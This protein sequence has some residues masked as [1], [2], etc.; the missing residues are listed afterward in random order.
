MIMLA[1][2]TERLAL[3]LA[4]HTG[5]TPE[6]V[7]REAVENQARIAGIPIADTANP[8]RAIN[9]DRV[10]EITHRVASRPLRDTRSADEIL[11]EAWG[12]QAE[13]RAGSL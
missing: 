13:C 8:R 10:R 11:D 9:M 3:L 6:D 12:N 7:L 1:P 4:E 2:E 5:K